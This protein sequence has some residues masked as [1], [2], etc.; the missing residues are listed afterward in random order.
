MAETTPETP[1]A[2]KR[3][4]RADSPAKGTPATAGKRAAKADPLKT[5]AAAKSADPAP[6]AEAKGRFSAALEE[7]KAGAAALRAEAES[8]LA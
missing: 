4:K 1:P 5:G 7:A 8:R 6:V 3:R 2:P